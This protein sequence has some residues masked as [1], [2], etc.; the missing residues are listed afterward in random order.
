MR[1]SGPI[2]IR[3]FSSELRLKYPHD[4]LM[5]PSGFGY[6]PSYTGVMV[7]PCVPTGASSNCPA[8]SSVQLAVTITATS[9]AI[10][11][12]RLRIVIPLFEST[13]PRPFSSNRPPRAFNAPAVGR[14]AG[15][16]AAPPIPQESGPFRG[17]RA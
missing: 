6:Q 12:D 9:P 5:V 14:L 16:A 1:L 11:M 10:D 15:S 2:G 17:A 3:T 4:T 8:E 7:C 13:A